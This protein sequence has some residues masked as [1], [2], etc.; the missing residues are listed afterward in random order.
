ME[1]RSAHI[2]ARIRVGLRI[3]VL[4][5]FG[6]GLGASAEE[7]SA[8]CLPH[9]RIGFDA[10]ESPFAA[11]GN[12][13]VSLEGRPEL[14]LFGRSL[15]VRR[16]KPGGYF[17][18][19]KAVEVPGPTDLRI[20]FCLRARGMAGV[21]VNLFD[22]IADDNTTPV[23]AARPREGGWTPVVF[24]VE[25]FRHNSAPPEERL[26]LPTLHTRLLFHGAELPGQEGEF[27]IDRLVIYRGPDVTPPGRPSGL[28]AAEDG[29]RVRLA[30]SE[31]EDDA[32][33]VV[34]GVYRRAEGAA[35]EKVGE[36]LAPR[37]EDAVG[38]AGRY[39]WRV[40]AADYE[41]NV[42][43]PSEAVSVSIASVASVS[44]V[45]SEARPLPARP[46]PARPEDDVRVRD[47][48]AYA[49]G[50]RTIHAR[51]RG[52]VRKDAFLALG[53]SITAANVYTYALSA[54]LG[55]GIFLR[56]GY[57]GMRTDFA[58]GKIDELLAEARPEFAVVMFGTNDPKDPESVR[59]A[60]ENLTYVIEACARAGTVPILATIPPRGYGK[61]QEGER[62]YNAA[63][64]ELCRSRRVPVSYVFEEMMEGDLRALLGDGVHLTP[65]RGNEAAASALR[66][67]FDQVLFALRDPAER[68]E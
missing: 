2:H 52:K 47:R 21:T 32:F 58:K 12:G 1:A 22:E 61:E 64:A 20:A 17:G 44:S 67:T 19:A 16:A 43:A 3:A 9:E 51:G 48:K 57:G 23:A 33:P 29:G 35:W 50:I 40:T 54:A 13:E 60:M 10:G 11:E 56:R 24:R 49:E 62:R 8:S 34:Y 39:S 5:I 28:T 6:G 55:R 36:S 31:P 53:D 15:R 66:K 63:L 68:R 30:W 7:P 59:G 26:T 41:D 37:F 42:S 4:S 65:E 25:E 27:W 45:D 38:E 46:L 18:A 14:A